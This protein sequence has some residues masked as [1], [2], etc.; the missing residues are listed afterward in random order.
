MH[1]GLTIDGVR[2]GFGTCTFLDG[3]VYAG[4]W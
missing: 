3:S 2:H 1:S 4:N